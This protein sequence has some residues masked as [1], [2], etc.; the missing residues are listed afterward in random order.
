MRVLNQAFYTLLQAHTAFGTLLADGTAGVYSPMIPQ[1]ANLPAVSFNKM[2]NVPGY[3]NTGLAYENAVYQV[4]ATDRSPSGAL[5]DTIASEILLA[6]EDQ[7][8][9]ISGYHNAMFIR[10]ESDLP[11]LQE[12]VDGLVIIHRGFL[13]RV[14]A[15]PS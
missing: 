13:F 12:V 10:R 15:Q 14:M 3:V 9:P 7:T 2:S 5:A 11:D 1:E 4:R 6:L 8:M